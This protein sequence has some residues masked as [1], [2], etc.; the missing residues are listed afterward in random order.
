M[1]EARKAAREPRRS[2]FVPST[3]A[4][5]LSLSLSPPLSLSLSLSLFLRDISL[6]RGEA[7][8]P[9]SHN[10]AE[11]SLGGAAG[12]ADAPQCQHGPVVGKGGGRW[13]RVSAPQWHVQRRP[14]CGG[15]ERAPPG[16]AD[17]RL[18]PHCTLPEKL[19]CGVQA[20]S[21]W[22]GQAATGRPNAETP[23]WSVLAIRIRPDGR[24]EKRGM[25]LQG[26]VHASQFDLPL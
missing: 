18:G 22:R 17:G 26:G 2:K 5:T 6:Q 13:D 8:Q 20:R 4:H 16:H 24:V 11:R 3:F 19:V 7:F 9:S 15:L 12:R 10:L 23:G 25:D 21:R 1:R 14:S